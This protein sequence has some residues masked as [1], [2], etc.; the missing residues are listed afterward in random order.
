MCTAITS[1]GSDLL[2][3]QPLNF[4]ANHIRFFKLLWETT[5]IINCILFLI[6]EG[7][8]NKHE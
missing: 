7:N 2:E 6:R 1:D 5:V 3:I 4:N 8:L